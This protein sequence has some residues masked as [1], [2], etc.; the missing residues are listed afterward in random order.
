M[1]FPLVHTTDTCT[2]AQPLYRLL[3]AFCALE[4]AV[5]V[6]VQSYLTLAEVLK[7]RQD[8]SAASRQESG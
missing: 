5:Q 1:P 7:G 4:T 6:H 2:Q 8:L 3:Q